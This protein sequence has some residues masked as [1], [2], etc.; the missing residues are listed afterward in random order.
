MIA[1]GVSRGMGFTNGE[2]PRMGRKKLGGFCRPIRGLLR[3]TRG[4]TADA[5]GYVLSAL[6]A[7][8]WEED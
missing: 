8:G 4:P 5:V 1:H 2:E 7:W 6:R 3:S